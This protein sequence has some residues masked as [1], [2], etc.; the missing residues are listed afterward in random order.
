MMFIEKLMP[1]KNIIKKSFIKKIKLYNNYN[2][3]IKNLSCNN[4]YNLEER[5]KILIKIFIIILI[6]IIMMKMINKNHTQVI[7]EKV[8]SKKNYQLLIKKYQ[9][10][11]IT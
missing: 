11:K 5:I 1:I 10:F 9:K 6:K 7:G 2:I 3:K 8:D 4:Q